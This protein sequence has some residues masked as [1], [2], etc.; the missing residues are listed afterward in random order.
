MQ[1]VLAVAIAAESAE[2]HLFVRLED[3]TTAAHARPRLRLLLLWPTYEVD[4]IFVA[5]IELIIADSQKLVA[6]F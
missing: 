3:E 5:Q 1:T 6:P 2:A 4:G